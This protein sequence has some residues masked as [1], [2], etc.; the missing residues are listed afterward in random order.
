MANEA[1]L[2]YETQLPIPFTCANGTG[3]EKGS[4]LKLADLMTVS[5]TTGEADVVGGIAAAEKIASDGKVKIPVYRAGIFRSICS[6]TITVGDPV[7]F[8]G[9]G[10]LNYIYTPV[11]NVETVAGIALET[12][13]DE[14]TIAFELKPMRQQ[15][16]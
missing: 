8:D 1:V 12:G 3:I 15:L 9:D 5:I 6:G 11:A 13:A 14:E 4:H 10:S 16:A 2:L 7:C